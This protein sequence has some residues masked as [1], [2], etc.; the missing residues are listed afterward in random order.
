M[1]V[2]EVELAWLAGIIDGEGSIQLD[3]GMR[4]NGRR[5][6]TPRLTIGNTSKAM[7]LEVRRLFEALE[8]HGHEGIAARTRRPMGIAVLQGNS[9][10]AIVK[11]V[12]PYLVAKA[13]QADVLLEY[14]L[15]RASYPRNLGGRRPF[16]KAFCEQREVF[17]ERLAEPKYRNDY[18]GEETWQ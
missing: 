16:P 5:S 10:V 1:A 8:V 3:A 4:K 17:L 9:A 11:A 13:E 15:W 12:R 6:C 7:M 18:K 2:T 14:V